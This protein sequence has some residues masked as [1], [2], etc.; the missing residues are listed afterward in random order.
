MHFKRLLALTAITTLSTAQ[1][2]SPGSIGVGIAPGTATETFSL[3]VD[4]TCEVVDSWV[5]NGELCGVYNNGSEVTCVDE[6][7]ESV[8]TPNGVFGDCVAV[9]EVCYVQPGFAIQWSCSV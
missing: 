4:S 7:V 1:I 6:T 5:G 9:R 3:I 8:S 2:C